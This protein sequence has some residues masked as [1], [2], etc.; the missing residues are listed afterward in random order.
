MPQTASQPICPFCSAPVEL[1]TAKTNDQ[2]VAVHEKCYVA[3]TL[4]PSTLIEN[5]ILDPE[6]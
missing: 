3:H 4:E 5:T 6:D 2:G 1:E